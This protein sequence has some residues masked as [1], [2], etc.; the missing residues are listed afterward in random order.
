MK[1]T[2]GIFRGFTGVRA[3]SK[4]LMDNSSFKENTTG[5]LFLLPALIVLGLFLF[6]PAMMSL[7]YS[8]TDYYMLTP[9][10]TEFIA[11]DNFK[12]LLS[13]ATFR[14]S[15]GNI[16]QFVIFIMPIQ[17]GT[18]LGLALLVNRSNRGT[19]FYKIA[20]FSPVVMSLVV[21]SVLWLYI[22][23]PAS[24]LLN[25]ILQTI[26]LPAQPF[27]SSPNQAMYVI[28]FVSAWQGAGYQML[29]FLAGL[30]NIPE[31][32]YEASTI[33]GAN[34][35]QQFLNVTLP[36]L[37]PTSLLILTTT[38]IDAFKLIIQPM[39]MTQGG[40]LNSTLTPV[41]Y[42]FRTGFT[43]RQI[44]FASALTVMYGG[45]IIIFTVLQRKFVGGDTNE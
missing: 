19:M 36:M 15:V 40:P 24:G 27:L 45:I 44:G 26:G 38:L 8:F 20:Y 29:I 1:N 14:T 9:D 37:K 22:L 17:V 31:E 7:Y 10:L 30:Q 23:N 18:A 21:V 25:E 11:L 12:T 6:I 43:D 2:K 32:V 33:D 3:N 42:I 5:Y 28:I 35:W 4:S 41:Y 39:V 16:F 13:D 34:K